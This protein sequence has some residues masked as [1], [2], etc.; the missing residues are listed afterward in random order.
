MVDRSLNRRPC[1]RKGD[2]LELAGF[3]G[4]RTRSRPPRRGRLAQQ[5]HRSAPRNRDQDHR[6]ANIINISETDDQL[7]RRYRSIH[8]T[9]PA[10]PGFNGTPRQTTIHTAPTARLS[11]GLK[12]D[13]T[14]ASVGSRSGD[15][16]TD[17][18]RKRIGADFLPAR[19]SQRRWAM[20]GSHMAPRNNLFRCRDGGRDGNGLV[21]GIWHGRVVAVRVQRVEVTSVECARPDV[22]CRS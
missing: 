18:G 21:V 13:P 8:S 22:A 4:S 5:R 7:T 9:G 6:R 14:L 16:G 19:G 12:A 3:V 20:R 10:Q 11:S 2:I 17:G 15:P 1:R